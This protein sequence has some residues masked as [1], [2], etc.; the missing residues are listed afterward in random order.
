MYIYTH[1]FPLFP[2][3][4]SRRVDIDVSPQHW[5][6][7]NGHCK[8]ILLKLQAE[9]L[10]QSL[11]SAMRSTLAGF[12][13]SSASSHMIPFARGPRIPTEYAKLWLLFAA[14]L[15]ISIFIAI[16]GVCSVALPSK[17]RQQSLCQSC[18]PRSHH[19]YHGCCIGGE[20]RLCTLSFLPP[21]KPQRIN[22]GWPFWDHLRISL[23]PRISWTFTHRMWPHN[24]LVGWH[25]VGAE[26][27]GKFWH[28]SCKCTC[29][30]STVSF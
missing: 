3:A 10:S 16:S 8:A 5:D 15:S 17:R 22:P 25:P 18:G 21:A 28:C 9:L 2:V 12:S 13:G 6:L 20:V 30:L 24:A 7:H 11:C 27:I 23:L 19:M 29:C 14:S 1:I 26:I 4:I